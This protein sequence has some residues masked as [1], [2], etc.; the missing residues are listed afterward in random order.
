MKLNLFNRVYMAKNS[1]SKKQEEKALQECSPNLR[2]EISNFLDDVL[3]DDIDDRTSIVVL[4]KYQYDK[5]IK[6]CELTGI[7]Y[8]IKDITNDVI[9]G[10]IELDDVITEFII[11]PYLESNLTTDIVLDKI[12]VKGIESLNDID[13]KILSIF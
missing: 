11:N 5:F 12:S 13:K 8:K 9:F 1:M 6:Y 7:T 2:E 4:N 3:H 10:D